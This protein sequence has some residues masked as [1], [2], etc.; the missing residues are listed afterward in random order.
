MKK[1]IFTVAILCG[2][3]G[4][5]ANRTYSQS[6]HDD[7]GVLVTE[8]SLL[9]ANHKQVVFVVAKDLRGPVRIDM[10]IQTSEG[11][12]NQFTPLQFPL[13][14]KQGQIV[15]VWNG[16]FN[17]FHTTPWLYIW[18]TMSTPTDVFYTNT[19]LPIEYREQY[20]EPMITSISETGGYTIPYT[21]TVKGIFDTTIPSLILINSGVFV[22]PKVITQTAP[23]II[24]FTVEAKTMD[25]FPPGKYLLTIC[26]GSHCDTLQGRHR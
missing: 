26:Q 1:L 6:Y 15:P 25:Q 9:A 20:K 21:I 14:V 18:I 23:G 12:V 8:D 13:G 24:R 3:F 4:V 22:S 5:G 17:S 11:L 10:Q 2:V 19:M 16:E 7:G